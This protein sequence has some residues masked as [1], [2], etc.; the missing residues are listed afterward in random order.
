MVPDQDFAAALDRLRVA[1]GLSLRD[2]VKRTGIARSTLSDALAGRRWPRL[3]TVLSVVEACGGDIES[4]RRRWAALAEAPPPRAITPQ[5]ADREPQP[6]DRLPQPA[7][8]PSDPAPGPAEP[9][10][11][12][13]PRPSEQPPDRMPRPAELPPDVVGF[14]GRDEELQQLRVAPL[15]VV[16]GPPGV[17][18]TSLVVHWAHQV[19]ANYPDGQLFLDLHGHHEQL[20]PMAAGNA[21]A[22]LLRSLGAHRIP[23]ELGEQTNLLRSLTATKRLLIILDDAVSADQVRP[24]L[25]GG[26]G[27]SVIVTSRHH[28]IELTALDGAARVGLEVLRPASSVALIARLI[29][30]DRVQA[31]PAETAAVAAACGHLPLA[32]RLAAATLAL[33]ATLDIGG[34]SERLTAPDRQDALSDAGRHLDA[35]FAAS[36]RNLDED[37]QLVFRR[38]SLH[39]GAQPDPA[40][41]AV[42]SG[43]PPTRARAALFALAEA[44][45]IEPAGLGRYRIHDLLREYATR[46]LA[47]SE[48]AAT[49][50]RFRAA[51][52]DWYLAHACS[53]AAVLAPGS[54]RLYPS[55]LP[56]ARPLSEAE[57][58]HWLQLQQGNLIAAIAA[59]S[60]GRYAWSLIDLLGV[61]MLR[62]Q[63]TADLL[64]AT[65]AGL[66]VA[67]RRADRIAAAA[68]RTVRAWL[69][70][71]QGQVAAARADFE[72]ALAGF[73]ELHKAGRAAVMLGLVAPCATEGEL[74][75]AEQYA[76][77]ALACYRE[78]ADEHGQATTLNALANLAHQRAD[79]TA[80]AEHFLASAALLR[81][82][83]DRGNL[84]IALGNLSWV[85]VRLG[86]LPA[87]I[88][89]STEAVD[90]A[91]AVEDRYAETL[92]LINGAVARE[93]AGELDLGLGWAHEAVGR[94]RE[95]ADLTF[96]ASA[97]NVLATIERRL[98]ADADQVVSRRARALELCQ[99]CD[100]RGN[101][102]NTLL[103]AARDACQR[104]LPDQPGG[105][106]S[107]DWPAAA[108][109][110]T[111]ALTLAREVGA[112]STEA[113]ALSVLAA[114]ALARPADPTAGE[115]AEAG[116]AGQAG[117][118]V[119][120]A[121]S[122]VRLQR[123]GGL[124]LSEARTRTVLSAA[125]FR[126]G[127]LAQAESEWQLARQIFADLAAPEAAL[128]AERVA[129]DA[130]A[131]EAAFV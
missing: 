24:I 102:A 75:L 2:L 103:S 74:V 108:E 106:P 118:A 10:P 62:R 84:A 81:R 91:R 94:A 25:P 93:Q 58:N 99:R 60:D 9:P 123:D 104:P 76:Q 63:D 46:L 51:L 29:G 36:Y 92:A 87:A 82:L 18:K 39:P 85:Y 14:A 95:L 32:L 23:V 101:E 1:R 70:W 38:L 117:E 125:L 107:S 90:N 131:A 122:A 57:A 34:L 119:E 47:S 98:G 49:R 96:Q 56:A 71:R 124:R 15:W 33:D 22:R 3:Q 69:R 110:A 53:V 83:G 68:V 8:P 72:L 112:R 121:G 48:D 65:D 17:G 114:C 115:T 26:A 113:E 127:T 52:F 7:E 11:D 6:A 128:L 66:A 109:L 41:V 88:D 77:Q 116:E 73:G 61:V 59:D 111:R 80:A 67:D 13:I 105:A 64:I 30:A 100:D 35:V 21:L 45:L 86:L 31:Q 19:A 54:A 50:A 44:H 120:L 16:H 89:C 28:L 12:P 37:G 42:L 4:W 78:L 130:G 43:L 5:P 129:Q 97:L 79:L 55:R 40:A 126:A 20:G 27:S